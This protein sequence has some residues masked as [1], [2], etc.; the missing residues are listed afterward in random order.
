MWIVLIAI[1]CIA[2][3]IGLIYN[4]LNIESS[5]SKTDYRTEHEKEIDCQAAWNKWNKEHGTTSTKEKYERIY[6]KC[7]SYIQHST[8][9]LYVFEHAEI[10]VLENETIQFKDIIGYNLVDNQVVLL[11]GSTSTMSTS[12]KSM[13]GR[14][15]VGGALTG[16]IGAVIGAATAK[17]DIITTPN[18][19]TIKHDYKIYLNLNNLSNPTRIIDIK[20]NTESAYKVANILNVIIERNK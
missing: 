20:D 10:I 2:L 15:V 18:E 13:L 6:G 8:W 9:H 16:G 7:S 12:T 4:R 19:Q 14:A 1:F 3:I 11:S 5:V 17:K